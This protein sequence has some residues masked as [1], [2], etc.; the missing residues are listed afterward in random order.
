VVTDSERRERHHAQ[1]NALAL[2]GNDVASRGVES[3]PYTSSE[4]EDEATYAPLQG[5]L[6][7]DPMSREV[8]VRRTVRRARWSIMPKVQQDC[9]HDIEASEDVSSK[10][11]TPLGGYVTGVAPIGSLGGRSQGHVNHSAGGSDSESGIGTEEEVEEERIE[12]VRSQDMAR[13]EKRWRRRFRKDKGLGKV[14]RSSIL[15]QKRTSI[16]PA[17]LGV[18]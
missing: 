18:N 15:I 12:Y 17:Q 10:D 4:D 5:D 9:G 13:A 8:E 3:E 16:V 1:I 2:H 7:P 11:Q 14:S 6:G